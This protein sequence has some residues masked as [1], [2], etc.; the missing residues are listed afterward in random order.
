LSSGFPTIDGQTISTLIID[1]SRC[2]H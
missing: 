1:T 2:H